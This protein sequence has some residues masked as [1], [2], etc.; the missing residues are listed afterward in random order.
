MSPFS[1]GYGS[2]L[3][4]NAGRGANPILIGKQG[5]GSEKETRGKK[6]TAQAVLVVIQRTHS[7]G[8]K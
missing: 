8:F 7:F 2:L 1:Q 3:T 6:A 5:K 4:P